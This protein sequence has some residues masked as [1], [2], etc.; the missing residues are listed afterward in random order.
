MCMC[1]LVLSSTGGFS[2][3]ESLESDYMYTKHENAHERYTSETWETEN[4]K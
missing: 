3:L 4:K 1:T 2:R